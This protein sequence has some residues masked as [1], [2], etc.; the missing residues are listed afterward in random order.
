MG[1]LLSVGYLT[2]VE[3]KVLGYMQG[4]KG[5]NIVGIYGLLQPIADGVKLLFKEIVIPQ[6]ASKGLYAGSAVM[7]LSLAIGG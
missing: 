1:V 2:L 7:A 5:P 4:R 6:Q 3:R